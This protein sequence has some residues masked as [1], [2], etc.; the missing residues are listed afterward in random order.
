MEYKV[1]FVNPQKQYADHRDEFI[2][3]FDETL[4]RGAIVNREEL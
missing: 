3:A 2:K 1:R 4:S